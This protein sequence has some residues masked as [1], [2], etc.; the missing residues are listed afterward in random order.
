MPV[1]VLQNLQIR[2]HLTLSDM[3]DISFIA[4][5]ILAVLISSTLSKFSLDEV[6]SDSLA[7]IRVFR[8]T[9]SS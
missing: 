5:L 7:L 6:D 1:H 2:G 3:S 8:R 4:T 9:C